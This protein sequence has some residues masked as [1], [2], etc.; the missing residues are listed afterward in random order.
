MK[1]MH[2][3]DNHDQVKKPKWILTKKKDNPVQLWNILIFWRRKEH[4]F[5]KTPQPATIKHQPGCG[6]GQILTGCR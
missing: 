6:A 4:G 1:Q 5:K 2:K 3:V